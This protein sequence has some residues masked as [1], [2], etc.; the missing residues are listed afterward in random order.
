[1]KSI[2][3]YLLLAVLALCATTS[4][5]DKNETKTLSIERLKSL[6]GTWVKLDKNGKATNEVVSKFKSIANGS[7]IIETEFPG[8]QHEMQ[9]LPIENRV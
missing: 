6:E 5:D 8:Q 1:M 3:P 7:T 9:E 4:A 2:A